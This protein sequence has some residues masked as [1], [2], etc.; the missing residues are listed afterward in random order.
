MIRGETQ[1][2]RA[3]RFTDEIPKEYIASSV[4][5]GSG[6]ALRKDDYFSL[7]P[8]KPGQIAFKSF[9]KEAALSGIFDKKELAAEAGG[10][11]YGE[12]DR[13]K[14]MKFGEGT[15]RD[16]KTG[17]RDYEVTVEFDTAGVKKMFASFAK[18]TKI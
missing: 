8:R 12:G 7:P 13:V 9:Q 15:V 2:N 5:S 16:I 4:Q 1:M 18:L 14:H 17:G 10:P 3:S 6:R 11:G